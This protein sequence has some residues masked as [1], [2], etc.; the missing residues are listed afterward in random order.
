MNIFYLDRD[1]V[2]AAQYHTNKHVIKMVLE[3]AQLLSTAHR[4]V[5]G[6]DNK[7]P[8]TDTRFKP[9]RD[10][11]LYLATHI[12]HPSAVWA[13]ATVGNYMWLYALFLA[14]LQEYTHRYGKT[15]ACN[16]LKDYLRYPPAKI[17]GSS[18]SDPPFCGPREIWTD[19]LDSRPSIV[20]CYRLYYA[21]HKI[22]GWSHD[23]ARVETQWLDRS[24]PEWLKI[25]A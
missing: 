17:V 21:T 23:L 5:D 24:V 9:D 11:V 22:D 1:P 20:E 19:N 15:H 7:L 12:S 4:V 6:I 25:P 14:L 2:L 10:D 3:T 18:F 13:R 8:D 16:K